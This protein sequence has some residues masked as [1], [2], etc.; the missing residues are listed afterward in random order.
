MVQ[1]PVQNNNDHV[2][3]MQHHMYQ[4][5]YNVVIKNNYNG[6]QVENLLMLLLILVQLLMPPECQKKKSKNKITKN[7]FRI[8][9]C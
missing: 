2:F 9:Y 8:E 4:E 5:Y 7:K 1:S 3:Q 6:I